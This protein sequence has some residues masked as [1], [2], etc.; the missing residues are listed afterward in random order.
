MIDDNNSPLMFIETFKDEIKSDNVSK[1]DS[2]KVKIK[3]D[4]VLNSD[5]NFEDIK[6]Y[7]YKD[8]LII[9]YKTDKYKLYGIIISLFEGNIVSNITLDLNEFSEFQEFKL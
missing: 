8:K 3:N 4:V 5:F 2:R 7:K 9:P 1:F 6:V